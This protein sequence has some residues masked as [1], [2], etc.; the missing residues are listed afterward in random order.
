MITSLR[1]SNQTLKKVVTKE[2]KL[3]NY[4]LK[5]PETVFVGSGAE[6]MRDR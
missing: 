1:S 4:W 5:Q 6:G 3:Y 2:R